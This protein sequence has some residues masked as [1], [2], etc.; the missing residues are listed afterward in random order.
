MFMKAIYLEFLKKKTLVHHLASQFA[1][2][3]LKQ[4]LLYIWIQCQG[5]QQETQ[6][7]RCGVKSTKYKN[8]CLGQ[9]FCLRHSYNKTGEKPW[10]ADTPQ[11]VHV[12]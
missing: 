4:S 7:S 3:F 12:F 8:H 2:D 10:N 5:M 9:N 11:G 1:V 6:S